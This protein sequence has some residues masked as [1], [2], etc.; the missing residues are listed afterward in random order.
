METVNEN[1]TTIICLLCM[2]REKIIKRAIEECV[3]PKV[4]E[5]LREALE[6]G[7]DQKER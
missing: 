4:L 5:I 3:D 2:L 1:D 6:A 7:D